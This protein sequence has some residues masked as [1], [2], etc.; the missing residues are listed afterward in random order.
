MRK[1]R[2]ERR[3]LIEEFRASKGHGLNGKKRKKE[4]RGNENE[5]G[6]EWVHTLKMQA[7]SRDKEIA[8]GFL[9]E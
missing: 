1:A 2:R 6:K 3:V 4:K 8:T 9:E 5:N 7:E